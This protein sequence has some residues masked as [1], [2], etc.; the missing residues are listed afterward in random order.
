M[1]LFENYIVV[2]LGFGDEGK[3]TITDFL[4]YHLSATAVVRYNGGPQAAHHVVSSDLKTHC[5]SQFSSGSFHKNVKTFL[6]SSMVIDPISILLENQAL[7]K[8]QVNHGLKNLE[9]HENSVVVTPFHKSINRILEMSRGGEVHGSCGLGVGVATLDSEKQEDIIIYCRDLWDETLLCKKLERLKQQKVEKADQILSLANLSTKIIQEFEKLQA[10]QVQAHLLPRY[11]EFINQFQ[12]RPLSKIEW[13]SALKKENRI[14]FEGAQG[15]LLDR[16]HG[17]FPYVTPSSTIPNN[18]KKI[19]DDLNLKS[20]GYLGILRAYHTR[21]GAGP[22]VSES[23]ELTQKIPDFHNG[24]GAWQGVFRIGWFDLVMAKYAIELVPQLDGLAITN[25]DRL[26]PFC[27]IQ[28]CEK[29]HFVGK[30]DEGFQHFFSFSEVGQNVEVTK[31]DSNAI[32]SQEDQKK[33]TN[34]LFQCKP[35]YTKIE[36]WNRKKYL[37][38]LEEKL[39][40]PVIITSSGMTANDKVFTNFKN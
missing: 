12:K 11:Q 39:G 2:G 19:K 28:I 16:N 29:Y 1:N 7:Q 31:I 4:T 24:R 21:H 32:H 5:F 35:I 14:V 27:D 37:Q 38:Q 18:A 40:L 26:E 36:S 25:L 22:F 33:L 13:D 10:I 9:L 8:N 30:V 23:E 15:V 17:F 34:Y 6:S 3:G 20:T